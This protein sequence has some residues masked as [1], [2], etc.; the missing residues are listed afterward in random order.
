M[1]LPFE[2]PILLSAAKSIE[3]PDLEPVSDYFNYLV[4]S[5]VYQ[6][7]NG[8]AASVIYGRFCALFPS[9]APQAAE[10]LNAPVEILRSVGL[11]AQKSAYIR[12]IA[13]FAMENDFSDSYLDSLSDEEVI[14]YLTQIK[15]VGRWTVEMLLIFGLARPDVFPA[16][17]YGI[18]TGMRELYGIDPTL[19][20]G[21]RKR[22][23]TEISEAWRPNR[24]LAVRYIW[25]YKDS[26]KKK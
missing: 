9:A 4:R 1:S 5:V 22:V 18:L 14:R 6:Q 8:K 25:A 2:D 15:G 21:K 12:H 16:D 11:S 19:P 10:I 26:E 24:S 17:D 7:L 3:L 20:A 23:M 13:E